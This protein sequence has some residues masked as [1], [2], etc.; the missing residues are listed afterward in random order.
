MPLLTDGF[1][2][3]QLRKAGV[4]LARAVRHH[5]LEKWTLHL[6][7]ATDLDVPYS[8]TEYN[9]SP[10]IAE[11][12]DEKLHPSTW[13]LA[14]FASYVDKG[15]TRATMSNRDWR[16]LRDAIIAES[17]EAATWAPAPAPTSIP[18]GA[19][20]VLMGVPIFDGPAT[21][22]TCADGTILAQ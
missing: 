10:A 11:W 6:L 17:T 15:A 14:L 18:P 3:A 1:M 22:F 9:L 7:D 8:V 19:H 21:S 20:A 4:P 13:T 2:T 16:A 12:V 5:E